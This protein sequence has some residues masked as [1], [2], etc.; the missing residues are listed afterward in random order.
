METKYH[1]INPNFSNYQGHEKLLPTVESL[2]NGIRRGNRATLSYSL[3]LTESKLGIH[4]K[5]AEELIQNLLPESG[6]SLR[7]GITGVP[8]VG[9]ST[10]IEAFGTYLI[11]RG[12]K[13]AV[14]AIDPTSSCSKGSI[15]G[16]KTRMEKLSV[17]QNAFI[18]PSPSSG[19]LG[20]VALHTR[21]AIFLLEA[22]GFDIIIVE[23][24][25]VGQS[26]VAVKSMVDFFLLLMLS[27]AGD[28]LQGIKKGIIEMA[29]LLLIN[30]ADG[31]N[32]K[33]AIKAKA[34]YTRTLQLFSPNLNE[35]IPQVDICSALEKKGMENVWQIVQQF[36]EQ[37]KIKGYFRQNRKEQAISWFRESIGDILLRK[38]YR[39]AEEKI[40]Q[41]ENR[42]KKNE[43]NPYLAAKRVIE[44][45]LER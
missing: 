24:V 11:E 42:V 1:A 38:F 20:G 22:T 40:S 44:E 31:D 32:L 19:S 45:F 2:A 26:E 23:T 7:I 6:N 30:K 17:N 33:E 9:K 34:E 43:V 15:L 13:V 28:E 10:F 14:L 12:K 37:Q 39:N 36:G 29:D 4:R 35:W 41:A 16:D 18:R 21:E 25:G 3:T 8:G 5:L 27:D